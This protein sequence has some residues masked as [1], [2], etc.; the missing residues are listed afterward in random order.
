MFFTVAQKIQNR[1][2]N[3]LKYVLDIIIRV[4]L[5]PVIYLLNHVLHF[6]RKNKINSSYF[7]STTS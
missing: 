2:H 7:A 1:L 5:K 3:K 6:L 4:K